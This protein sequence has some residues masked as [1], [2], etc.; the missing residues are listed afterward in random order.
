MASEAATDTSSAPTPERSWHAADVEGVVRRLGTGLTSGLTDLEA[1]RRRAA[2]GPNVITEARPRGAWRML[3][4][5]VAD[6]TVLLLLGAALV[7]GFTGEPQDTAA[8]A[9]IVLVNAALGFVQEHRAER[10]M[11]A[12][13]ALA[14]PHA[15]VRRGG[16][17]RTVPAADLVPGDVVVLEAG[18]AVPAD[19]RVVEA[20]DLRTNE[21]SLTGESEPVPKVTHPLDAATS[22]LGD[23]RNLAYKGTLVAC[24]RGLGVVVA[25]GMATELGRIAALLGEERAPK[26]PLQRRLAALGHRLALA[27]MALCAVI[28]VV[29]LVRGEAPLLMFMTALSLAVAAIPEALPA[30]V[31]VALALGARRMVRRH[32]LIRR[33]PAVETLG[34]VTYVCAD[35][36]GT[37]T[38]NRMQVAAFDVDGRRVAEAP[39]DAA[40]DPWA[41][42]LAALA[43]DN[44]AVM[45]ESHAAEGEPTEVALL[46]AAHRAGVVKA[47]LEAAM[48]RL[49]EVPFSPERARMTTVH[50]DRAGAVLVL[51]KG[52]PE[53]VLPLC[54]TRLTAAGPAALDLDAALDAAARMAA[55]GLRVLAFASRRLPAAPA[56]F[57]ADSVERELALL[58]FVGLLDPPRPG[59]RDAVALCRSAGIRVVMITGDHPATARAVAG[60]LGLLAADDRIV[61]GS[62]LARLSLP[63]LATQ[64]PRIRVFARV[65]P[66]QKLT[67][68]RLLQA[69]GELVAMTGDGVNDAPALQCADIGVAMGRTGT[70][71]A[72][73]AADMVLLDDDFTTIV[74]AVREGR[75]IYDNIRKFVRYVLTGNSA[76][77]WT[78]LLA[79]LVLL[80]VP[81]LPIHILWINLVTDGLPGLALALEPAETGVMRRPPRAPAESFFAHGLWQHAVWVGLLMGGVTLATQAW[82]LHAESAHWQSMTFTVLTFAQLGHVLA[83]RSER[84]SL[85][86]QGL[87]SNAPLLGAVTLTM[88]LHGATLYVPA[89][90]G[91]FKTAPLSPPEVLG[92]LATAAIPF[93]AV[94]IE[95]WLRRRGA[96]ARPPRRP[97]GAPRQPGGDAASSVAAAGPLC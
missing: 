23:R 46:L 44:D 65:A 91:V 59:A 68:V 77:L 60:R 71:V 79:P 78:L 18:D 73:E 25:T 61:T 54:A 69:R 33:L 36:T 1:G 90:N 50:A 47:A 85:F 40:A 16:R 88:L 87:A 9:A 55:D 43:L 21:A 52:A 67:I 72:R 62:E 57:G 22:S 30:V 80:P 15:R 51:T 42:L 41:T 63:E 93:A 94:E 45:H 58:G 5:Q 66:E 38:E 53:R 4:D 86:T 7:A 81:L 12:L 28:F 34:S 84:D 37:L 17:L 82:A 3:L 2:H 10:A 27:V 76:E 6:V 32:A 70:D 14:A 39:R 56:D 49:A 83:I 24:G 13:R 97:R 29:G 8:I 35:K 74:S 75:R 11:T 20:A 95:K 26:T 92:C 96:L 31:T 48:P 89:L 64:V 19:V